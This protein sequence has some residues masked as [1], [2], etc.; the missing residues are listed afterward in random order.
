MQPLAPLTPTLIALVGV[1]AIALIVAIMAVGS[2]LRQRAVLRRASGDVSPVA[3]AATPLMA[4]SAPVSELSASLARPRR[5]CRIHRAAGHARPNGADPSGND[6][7]FR[8]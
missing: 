8:P 5:V 6:C 2:M 3:A 7:A 4:D 1:G